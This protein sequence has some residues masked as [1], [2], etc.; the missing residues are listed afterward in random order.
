MSGWED[1]AIDEARD[2]EKRA[3]RAAAAWKALAKK[4]LNGR[5]WMEHISAVH[6]RRN[7]NLSEE[8]RE[9]YDR[10]LVAE[11]ERDRLRA[12]IAELEAKGR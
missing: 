2:G 9:M 3:R 12:R 7:E 1:A 11:V 5:R 6:I 10:A 4:Y 8:I